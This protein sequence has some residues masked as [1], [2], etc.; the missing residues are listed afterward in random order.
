MYRWACGM[1]HRR[2]LAAALPMK[3]AATSPEKAITFAR[4]T[5]PSHLHLLGLGRGEK[6]VSLATSIVRASPHAV[7][8]ADA[9][10]STTA[11]G[12]RHRYTP[13]SFAV[14]VDARKASGGGKRRDI[15][16]RDRVT[17]SKE[18][19]LD[20]WLPL[21]KGEAE[22]QHFDNVVQEFVADALAAWEISKRQADLALRSP[23]AAR[24]LLFG[25]LRATDPVIAMADHMMHRMANTRV[26]LVS[27]VV[28]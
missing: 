17:A 10:E 20:W 22:Q 3:K 25:H 1:F 28:G 12:G 4:E 27:D 11:Y 14:K 13:A 7:V 26:P 19:E 2:Q 21:P 16:F 18:E 24:R 8:T 6:S 15:Y 9:V 5:K 23:L